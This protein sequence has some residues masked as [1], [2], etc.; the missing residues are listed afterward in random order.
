MTELNRRRLLQAGLVTAAGVAT[1]AAGATHAVAEAAPRRE[2]RLSGG[3]AAFLTHGLQH[4]AWLTT[5]EATSPDGIALPRPTARQFASSGFTQP[6]YYTAGPDGMYDTTYQRAAHRRL[7]SVA[8]FPTGRQQQGQPADS[9][10]I[11]GPPPPADE[12]LSP[13]MHANLDAMFS[14]CFGDE[15]GYS[16]QLVDWLSEYYAAMRSI[17][18]HVL[19]YNNQWAGE[20]SDEQLRHYIRTSKP[21]L[22]NWDSYYF[23][24][25][26]PWSSGS[27]TPL[28]SRTYRYRQLALEGL[29]GSG[30]EPI[31]FGTYTQGFQ[32][33]PWP[34]VE[35]YIPSESQLTL[36]SFV[37]WAM[38]A[39]LL[40]L[41]RW[42][43]MQPYPQYGLVN[44]LDGRTTP[45][46]RTYQQLNTAMA[47]LSPYLTRLRTH[48]VSIRRGMTGDP[49][50][51]RTTDKSTV[52]DW[53]PAVDRNAGISNLEVTN[54]GGANQGLPGD[55]LVGTFRT[56]PG[57]SR[58]NL[59]GVVQQDSTAIMLVNA[60]AMPRRDTTHWNAPGGSGA[61]T[62]QRVRVTV[63]RHPGRDGQL[64]RINIHT[65]RATP[66]AARRTHVDS[67]TF[68]EAI[69]G[70]QGVLLV[71]T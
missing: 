24:P 19:C 30:R 28:Y 64:S 43:W 15:E 70:G 1:A 40:D 42:T 50:D 7:W 45:I 11:V 10:H 57:L 36:V 23:A 35:M 33:D 65:G 71:W 46:Y 54:V 4:L 9:G 25:G 41:F 44:Y 6:C 67:W 63:H 32:G 22:I 27:V 2:P 60:L 69:D 26:S 47:A 31:N 17:A 12:L 18:P 51:P 39:K 29:D 37:A 3:D 16:S 5:A 34:P 61:E 48:S 38:G 59:Q 49:A 68:D 55:V 8:Q 52:P 56:L 20:W 21:D 53:T 13:A 62:R 58:H 66:V 14:A